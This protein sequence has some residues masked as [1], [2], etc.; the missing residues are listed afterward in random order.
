[1][2]RFIVAMMLI[3]PMTAFAGYGRL[4]LPSHIHA[5]DADGPVGGGPDSSGGDSGDSGDGGDGGDGGNI[6]GEDPDRRTGAPIQ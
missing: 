2:H 1:M 4:H 6:T 5:A 3:I